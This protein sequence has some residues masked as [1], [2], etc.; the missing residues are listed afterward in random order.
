MHSMGILPCVYKHTLE[1]VACFA[2]VFTAA[3]CDTVPLFFW[4]MLQ[5][6]SPCKYFSPLRQGCVSACTFLN[7][8]PPLK[9]VRLE[10]QTMVFIPTCGLGKH[11]KTVL[12]RLI[13]RKTLS[14]SATNT[15]HFSW[16]WGGGWNPSPPWRTWKN[17]WRREDEK[18]PSAPH[19][20]CSEVDAKV[21]PRI[22]AL[23]AAQS[24]GRSRRNNWSGFTGF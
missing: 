4:S 24:K 12:V 7:Q 8:T 21:A 16:R 19:C 18:P 17:S 6:P 5:F 15:K 9:R 22:S 11:L 1:R 14:P 20:W 2:F 3:E 13:F 23:R 10:G